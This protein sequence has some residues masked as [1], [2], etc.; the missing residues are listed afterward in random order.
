MSYRIAGIDVHKRMLAVVVTDVEIESEY[1][2]EGRMFGSSPDQLR[3]LAAWLLEQ[4]AEEV[5]MESTA[6][7]W[8]PVWEA[9]ERY[10]KPIR[11]KREGARRKSGTLH[12]AQ[13][14]SNRGRRGRKRDFPDAARL[15]KRLVAPELTLSFVP[16]PD[17]PLTPTVTR[18]KYQLRRDRV[19]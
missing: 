16:H 18:K 7:Y 17:P 3:S 8:K 12:L 13:A 1:E 10:W 5:V 15:V 11:E 19:R 14:Q 4:E 6:Q 2:L 9:L